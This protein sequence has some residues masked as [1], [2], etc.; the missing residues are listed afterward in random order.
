[1]VTN[2]VPWRTTVQQA[3]P[4]GRIERGAQAGIEPA[5]GAWVT[6]QICFAGGDHPCPHLCT[7]VR[8]RHPRS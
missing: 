4:V 2:S 7:R 5:T 1:M 8:E 3:S 6:Q